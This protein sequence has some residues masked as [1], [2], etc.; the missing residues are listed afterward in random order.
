MRYR[1]FDQPYNL[2]D[3]EPIHRHWI[4][5]GWHTID[6][7]ERMEVI[8]DAWE[9]KFGSKFG[10]WGADPVFPAPSRSW[11]ISPLYSLGERAEAIEAEFTM[12]MLVA[13][14]RC[15]PRGERLLAIGHWQRQWYEFDPHG[16]ITEAT[17]DEWAQAILPDEATHFL[18]GDLRFG[19]H[20]D[21]RGKITIFGR[22]L[23]AA[24]EADPP[25]EFLRVCHSIPRADA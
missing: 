15:V 23:F 1:H 18:A 20:G 22:E 13:F 21:W 19:T 6:G 12:K 16:P 17:R 8:A 14:R 9:A 25:R 7:I 11:D 3:F 10:I 2:A 24:L 4:S 5:I